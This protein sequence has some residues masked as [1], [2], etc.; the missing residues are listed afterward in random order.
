MKEMKFLNM[1]LLLCFFPIYALADIEVNETN[2]PDTNFR[3]YLL[4]QSYGSDG[5]ITDAEINEITKISVNH[6]GISD[7]KGIEFFTKLI[8]L[9]SIGNNLSSLDMSKNTALETLYISLNQAPLTLDVTNNIELKYLNCSGDNLTSLDVSKN[10][11]LKSLKCH[12]NQLTKL[13]LSKNASITTLHCQDNQ[14]SSL[15]VSGCNILNSMH[16]YNNLLSEIDLSSNVKLNYLNCANNDLTNLNLANNTELEY[17][18]C[19]NNKIT[20]LDLSSNHIIKHLLCCNN[21]I[22]SSSMD[23]LIS[24]LPVVE[25]GNFYVID[26]ASEKEGNVCTTINVADLKAKGWVSYYSIE[27]YESGDYV[28]IPYEGSNPANVIDCIQNQTKAISYYRLNGSRLSA[29]QKGIN[30]L[31]DDNGVVKKLVVK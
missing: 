4:E 1:I 29:L 12:D 14:I 15:E 28:W 5:I 21:N 23:L 2:F 22:D 6:K 25:T 16:C 8:E 18:L 30:I 3:K 31:R 11:K 24:S 7:L 13:N 19:D 9:S 26:A 20:S 17:L 27:K 10:M